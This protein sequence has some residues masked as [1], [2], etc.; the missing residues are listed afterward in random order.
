MTNLTEVFRLK[1]AETFIVND[2][3]KQK[4]ER[5]TTV[6]DSVSGE[7][8]R[9]YYKLQVKV[10]ITAFKPKFFSTDRGSYF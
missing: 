6:K 5:S 2:C 3:V 4:T 10:V 1:Q 8:K 7:N 9:I